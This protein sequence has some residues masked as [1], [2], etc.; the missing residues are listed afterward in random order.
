[1]TPEKYSAANNWH[2]NGL[3]HNLEIK[4]TNKHKTKLKPLKDVDSAHRTLIIRAFFV[5][6]SFMGTAGFIFFGIIGLLCAGVICLV[7]AIISVSLSDRL[8]R[9]AG[10]LF[11]GREPILNI[12]ERYSA[13]LSRAR[14]QKM[15]K[16][17]EESLQIIENVL[18]NES[19]FNE[20]L[21]LKAQ[22]LT[23][24]F[25]DIDDAKNCL[26]KIFQTEPKDTQLFQWSETFYK[27]LLK[28]NR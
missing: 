5:P 23:E 28:P 4:K 3:Y 2:A 11:G 21:F 7:A 19:S 25:Y 10:K 13:D 18:A 22:I 17:Y 15:N 16:N 26:I 8:G 6:F 20:A 24:G 12:Q 1:M 27:K 14:V 9:T